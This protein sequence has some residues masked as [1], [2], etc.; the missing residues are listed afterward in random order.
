MIQW[1]HRL[2]QSWVA[3]IF[4]GA[5]AL[6]FVVW[7]IADVFTGASST[8]VA[9]VGGT[10]IDSAVFAR[11]Y[12]NYVRNQ[13]QQ[14]GV[15]IT[16][17]M[18]EKMGLGQTALQGM[19]S[20]TALDNAL[21]DMHLGTS[22]AALRDNVRSAPNFHG[23]TGQFDHDTF[24][25][26]I[27]GAGYAEQDFLNEIRGNM[28]RDQ[29][30]GALEQGF[31][32]PEGYAQALFQY[33]TEKRAANYVIVSPDSLGPVTAPDETTLAAY[34]KAH[35]ERFSTPEYR[36]IEY[37]TI[38]PQDLVGQVTVTDAM[39][40]Q[41]YAAHKATYDI[42][43]KRDIQQ[44]EFPTEADAK[45]GRAKLDG[46]EK[47]EALAA[48]RK[49]KPADLTLGELAKSELPD[50]ARADAAFNLKENEVSQPIKGAFGG[51]VL[52]RVTKI[53]PGVL[54]PL[55][56]V[57]D[58]IKKNLA[59]QL[60]AGKLVDIIN[61]FEDARS[62]G[63]NIAAASQKTGMKSGRFA[64]LDKTG[65]TP[66][67]EKPA[68]LP[69]DPEFLEQAFKAEPGEDNDPFPAKSGVYY[70]VKV[71]G[72]TQPKL[73][74]LDLVRAD[75]IASWSQEQKSGALAKKAAL[76]AAEA[77][78]DKNLDAIARELKVPVQHSPGLARDTND[79]TF[80]AALTG[81]IFAAP[82]DGIVTGQQGTGSNFI[83]AQVSGINHST[84][85]ATDPT[86]QGGRAQLSAQ[87]AGDMSTSF[88]NAARLAQ[89]VKVNQ[90][91]LQ[92]AIG[93]GQ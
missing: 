93:S 37:A 62:G 41:D 77:Q 13:S 28:T 52:M 2:S 34:V 6:S 61:A 7:G 57:A 85:P 75:A 24:L 26:A 4:M 80:S 68:G 49:I 87:A 88:A 27:Q 17:D 43:E 81:K 19:V 5:L 14:M 45:A 42:P 66:T 32:L 35:P 74:P 30:T 40:A 82:P 78:K 53:V 64:A 70:A 50:P 31:Q 63:A 83:I 73:K 76:L 54:H 36:Q 47:F 65:M 33:V 46:G 56:E 67:G 22:D 59:L 51:F 18:A 8:A 48:D 69:A 58:T 20:R 25:R 39:V 9:T 72:V 86:F 84:P 3:T 79:T 89:G 29:L 90:K 15:E 38:G 23:A 10:E 12:R 92:S 55:S 16:P 44:I 60:A 71:D 11:S 1:M 21:S 91:V